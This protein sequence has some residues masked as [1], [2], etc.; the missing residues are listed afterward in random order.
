MRSR[1]HHITSLVIYRLKDGHTHTPKQ[2]HTMHTDIAGRSNSK[3]P[4]ERRLQ[5]GACLVKN[6]QH[7]GLTWLLFAD[8]FTN[9]P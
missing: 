5:G 6:Q 2:T 3:K 9:M 8:L 7:F 4:G 1:S